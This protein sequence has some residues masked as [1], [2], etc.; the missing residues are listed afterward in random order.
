MV[1]QF[2]I[3]AKSFLQTTLALTRLQKQINNSVN[4]SDECEE[5]SLLTNMLENNSNGDSLDK[6]NLHLARGEKIYVDY[7]KKCWKS[8]KFHKTFQKPNCSFQANI[9]H[10]KQETSN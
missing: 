6:K 10:V 4:K 1:N 9:C 3:M 2:V 5:C 8:S 7:K